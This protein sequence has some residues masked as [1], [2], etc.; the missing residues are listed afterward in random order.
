M[1]LPCWALTTATTSGNSAQVPQVSTLGNHPK[2]KYA[3]EGPWCATCSPA[4]CPLLFGLARATC[5]Y[6]YRNLCPGGGET[7]KGEGRI[8]E[9]KE[10]ENE[11]QEERR[12]E[13]MP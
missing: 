3:H 13:R 7:G 2:L 4:G 5:G 10:R 12:R 6:F 1:Q 9:A 11:R 8:G